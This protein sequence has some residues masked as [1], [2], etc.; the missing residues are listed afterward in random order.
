MENTK[1]KYLIKEHSIYFLLIVFIIIGMFTSEHFL[2]VNNFINLLQRSSVIGLISLGM[3]FVIIGG[4]ID[5]SVGSI[6][7]FSG[8]VVAMLMTKGMN[9]FMALIFTI[10]L[11]LVLGLIVGLVTVKFNLPSFIVSLA[12]MVSARGLA[13]LISNGSPVFGLAGPFI[14]IGGGYIG[15]IPFSI[16]LWFIISII[17]AIVLKYTAFGRKLYALGGNEEAAF[18]SGIK[19]SYYKAI[20]FGISGLLSGIAGIV[21]ASWLTV[22]QPSAGEGM[23]LDAIASVVL[24]GTSLSGGSGTI[25]GT[26]IGVLIL[27]I[28]TNIFNLFGI[29]SYYQYIFK[30]LIIA[31]ALILNSMVVVREK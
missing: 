20:S 25:G 30:G 11:T 17:S 9:L 29:S 23:E 14:F 16:I 12:M 8:I 28:I 19:T 31:G 27:S 18:Y 13:L 22:A 2:T 1:F 15:K 6:V 7:A 3:T 24:G 5:L 10:F 4:G 26:I 21:L